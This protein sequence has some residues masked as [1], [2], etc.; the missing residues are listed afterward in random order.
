MDRDARRKGCGLDM[1]MTRREF[2]GG[3]GCL[4]VAVA[5]GAARSASGVTPWDEMWQRPV[6]PQE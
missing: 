5:L 1:E 6:S 4:A 3:V 2:L